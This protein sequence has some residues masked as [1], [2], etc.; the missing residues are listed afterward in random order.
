MAESADKQRAEAQLLQTLAADGQIADSFAYAHARGVSH[1][2]VVGVM[3]SLLT[4]AFVADTELST[5]FYV[6][7]DEARGFLLQGSPEVQVFNAIPSDGVDR[8]ALEAAVGAA[9]LKVGQGACMKNKWIRLDKADGKIYRNVDAVADAV[10]ELL[11]RIEQADG[12]LS[13]VTAD[14]ANAL[15]RRKLVE[16]R[17]RKSYTITKGPNFSVQRKKQATGLTKEMLEG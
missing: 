2:L 13:A 15:K 11:R 6:L 1:E 5:S 10:T 3:K 9:V 17:T 14:E 7:K 16:I 12:A 8:K 4:D